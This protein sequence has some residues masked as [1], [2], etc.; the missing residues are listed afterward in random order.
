MKPIKKLITEAL[1]WTAMTILYSIF[2]VLGV[3]CIFFYIFLL[4]YALLTGRTKWKF[5]VG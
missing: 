2:T 3:A 5:K 1:G 4:F